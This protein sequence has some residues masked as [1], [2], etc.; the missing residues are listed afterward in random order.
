MSEENKWSPEWR[1]IIG[2]IVSQAVAT[3]ADGEAA[4]IEMAHPDTGERLTIEI[5][6]PFAVELLS[7][8]N[9]TIARNIWQEICAGKPIGEKDREFL[10]EWTAAALAEE[11]AEAPTKKPR[12]SR[13]PQ[14]HV[15]H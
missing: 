13:L 5:D 11:E 6:Q 10:R 4:T 12:E 8:A 7:W 15:L 1:A 2:R 9:D 14:P 3:I